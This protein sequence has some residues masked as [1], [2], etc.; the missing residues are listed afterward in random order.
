MTPTPLTPPTRLR[1]S[2]RRKPRPLSAHQAHPHKWL[3]QMGKTSSFNRSQTPLLVRY[4]PPYPPQPLIKCLSRLQL[5]PLLIRISSLR[6]SKKYSTYRRNY[7]TNWKMISCQCSLR[8]L[9]RSWFGGIAPNANQSDLHAPITAQSVNDV[10]LE[11]TIIA[12]GLVIVWRCT[13]TST[14]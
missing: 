3:Q 8:T 7:G 9:G 10:C 5:R 4:S 11:W 14:F 2:S 6:S 12:L 1:G 13:T